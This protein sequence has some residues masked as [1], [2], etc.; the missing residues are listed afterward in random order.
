MRN[1]ETGME[2]DPTTIETAVRIETETETE[3]DFWTDCGFL[4]C[5]HCG[6][7]LLDG[8]LGTCSVCDAIRST[9]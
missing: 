1:M 7:I 9:L 5:D 2:Y 8:E 4:E 3:I 6:D